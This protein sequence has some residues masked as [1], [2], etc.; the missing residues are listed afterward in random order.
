M[1]IFS[2]GETKDKLALLHT[3]KSIGIGVTREQLLRAVTE[4]DTMGYFDFSTCLGELEADGLVTARVNG[5]GQVYCLTDEGEEMLSFFKDSL[6][7]SLRE[8]LTAYAEANRSGMARE[9]MLVSSME[10]QA[11]GTYLI[12]LTAQTEQEPE[13]DIRLHVIS[14]AMAIRIRDAWQK[15]A[16]EA[17]TALIANLTRE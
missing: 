16:E 15:N 12:R 10:E 2:R 17:Y 9:Q 13:V 3:V 11:D 5:F 8:K 1:P 14:R 4:T 6:P 7:Y